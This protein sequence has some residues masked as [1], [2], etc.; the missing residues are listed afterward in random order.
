VKLIASVAVGAL[1]LAG[2][3]GLGSELRPQTSDAGGQ[4]SELV[5]QRSQLTSIDP[6]L[7]EV[8]ALSPR[9]AVISALV[10]LREQVDGTELAA[11]LDA[12]GPGGRATR[13]ER[14]A[15]VVSTL[16]QTAEATQAGLRATLAQLAG[17]GRVAD[18]E[19]F[20]IAN[21]IRVDATETE[22]RRIA[23][24]PDVAR[25]YWNMPISTIR[26]VEEGPP[27]EVARGLRRSGGED[28]EIQATITP[29]VAAVRAPDVWA[30]GYTGEGVLVGTLDTGVNGVHPAVASRWRGHDPQYAGNPG[31]AWFDPLTG[32]TFPSDFGS[33]HGTHT[34]GTVLGG[35]PGEQ[36][37]V[38]PGA[39]WVHAAVIDRGG[40][41]ATIQNAI[42]A[43]Q[44]MAAPTG[45]PG[46]TWAVPHVCSNSWGTHSGH[47]HPNCD[48]LFW[49]WIDNS[50]AAGTL[51]LFS[52]GNEGSQGAN[53][54]RRPADRARLGSQASDY[55]SVAVAAI[56]PHNPSW[57]AAGFS[58]RGPTYCTPDGSAFT[59]PNISAPGVNTRSSVGSSGYS[60]LSGT[61]MASPH[62]NGVVALMIEACDS[63][64][65]DEIKQI[66]YDTAVDLGP[67]GKDNTYGW[68]MIDAL[69]AVN[70]AIGSCTLGLRLP[71]GVPNM[72][73]PGVPVTFLVEVVEGSE[74]V[75]PGSEKLFYRYQS[76]TFESVNLTPLGGG[77]YDAT[78]PVPSCGDYAEFYVEV[79]GDGGSIRRSPASAP[80]STYTALVGHFET[81]E[82]F[83][84]D[85]AAGLPA[86]WTQTGLWH[87][88]NACSVGGSCAPGPQYSY[89][90]QSS[91]PNAC[92]FNTG[93]AN[94]GAMHS[95]QVTFPNIS[96]GESI[97]L[98]FCYNLETENHSSYDI[99]RFRVLGTSIDQR[100]AEAASWTQFSVDVT[101]HAGETRT[102]QWHFDTVDGVLNNF[103][104]WQVDRVRI[105]VTG[106]VC[107]NPAPACPADLNGDGEV[108]VLD[109]LDLLD[110]WGAN[111]GHPADLNG[112]G[113]VDVL[114]LLE[115]LDAWGP[116]P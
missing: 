5:G 3:M 58:S 28:G 113:E 104:G 82:V 20:W 116:C 49:Q 19:S 42:L 61:S 16:R 10:F 62:V 86:G 53:S 1:V 78:L 27:I 72:L 2:G 94:S 101:A 87:V 57:P 98:R 26:P 83:Y 25:V 24:R 106:L 60:N 63:L 107:E 59:K 65:N 38:A 73:D 67:A 115:L 108:D 31:W 99:A 96:Q 30:M 114:D 89:Y 111:P 9:G 112:D 51:Q 68:G 11:Q 35:A 76:G 70:M 84:R 88:T 56:D 80:Q 18:Y 46:D 34:M 17:A 44:W 97:T 6:G 77:F 21:I 36:V 43:F 105:E 14:N 40:L 110:A 85:F 55:H 47:G 90:G 103:R 91:G 4:K 37:G 81:T 64:T 29:G 7:E 71:N 75:V 32:T 33:T 69:E 12:A 41:D 109:L 22:L 48:E 102:L 100:L 15:A 45:S 92:T 93:A 39:T 50:E 52:A 54:L 66:I 79:H 13:A 74:S 95:E 8:F 23:A